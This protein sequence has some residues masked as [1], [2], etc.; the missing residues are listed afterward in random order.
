MLPE[1][2]LQVTV[3]ATGYGVVGLLKETL[4]AGF[5]FVESDL[6]AA[7]VKVDGQTVIFTLLGAQLIT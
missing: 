1:G 6:A 2:Q 4:P 5:T 7:T 3:T